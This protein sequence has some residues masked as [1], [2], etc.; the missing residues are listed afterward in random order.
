MTSRSKDF[1]IKVYPSAG[2]LIVYLFLLLYTFRGLSVQ[3]LQQQT[4][5]ARTVTVVALYMGSVLVMMALEQMTY[6]DKFKAAWIFYTAPVIKPGEIIIGAVKSMLI[7]FYM[8]VMLVIA[9]AGFALIGIK[10][11]PNLLLAI[12]NIIFSSSMASYLTFNALPFSKAPNTKQQ[13]GS[14]IKNISRVLIIG[15]LGVIHYLLY[16]IT[17]VIII[18]TILAAIAAWY[19]MDSI[20]TTS[21]SQLAT[22]ADSL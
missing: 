2:Y 17:P 15:V 16:A 21:W 9:V 14:F 20:K 8:P 18:L 19:V 4:D 12:L 5:Q 7:K 1:R 6:S 10:F 3:N 11:L 22:T 13:S